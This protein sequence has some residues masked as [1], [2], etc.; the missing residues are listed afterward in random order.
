MIC[1]KDGITMNYVNC[2]LCPRR[3]RVNREAGQTGFCRCPD[4]ALVS[5]TMLHKW[6]EPAL[7]G[8]KG[9]GAIFF[10]GCTMGC[11]YCQNLRISGGPVGKPVSGTEL[12]AM[13]EDL[14][15]QGAENI[16]LVP[17]DLSLSNFDRD[18]ASIAGREYLL[19]DLL[20]NVKDNYDFIVID[21]PPALGLITYNAMIAADHLVMVTTA[22]ALSYSGLVMVA[23]LFADVKSNERLNKG[24]K[25]TGVVVTRYEKNKLSELYLNKI[26]EELGQAF[27]SPVIRKATKMQQA[28]SIKQSI[29]DLDP[30]GKATADY[31]D[32]AQNLAL[33]ILQ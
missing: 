1:P 13:M 24:L 33:R 5:K 7:A 4:R 31:I 29:Y 3:C 15:A 20:K 25:L 27:I 22:D 9:S 16:D 19:L 23:N 2:E 14:I 32:V 11:V 21:C 8:E 12:R 10:G 18:T 28:A 26:K 30:S 6:E 17:S